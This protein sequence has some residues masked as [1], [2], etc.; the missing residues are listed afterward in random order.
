[1]LLVPALLPAVARIDT[2]DSSLEW[3]F[4]VCA[5]LGGLAM[6]VQIAL[7]LVGGDHD[8]HV[9]SGDAGM[10]DHEG[11]V[12]SW[13][14]LR[15]IVALITFFGLGGMFGLSRDMS[16]A[17]SVGVGAACG[18]G[19]LVVTGVMLQ[20]FAKL[21]ATGTVDIHNAVGAEAKVYLTVPAAKAGAGA[22]TV[23]IQGRTMQFRAITAGAELKT[24][25]LCRVRS[26]HASDTLLVDSV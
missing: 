2:P 10:P 9:D 23:A 12:G 25:E 6:L 3:I 14:S 18:F 13:V 26:V 17:A 1:M 5:I 19:A 11:G 22:V 7:S 15:A 24:G 8:V 4:L 20:Q 21:R 16:A